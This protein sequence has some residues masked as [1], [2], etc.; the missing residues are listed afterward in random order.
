MSWFTVPEAAI[1][2]LIRVTLDPRNAV[3]VHHPKISDIS[4]SF[5]LF[6]LNGTLCRPRARLMISALPK[7]D[8]VISV[9]VCVCCFSLEAIAWVP[10]SRHCDFDSIVINEAKTTVDPVVKLLRAKMI[11][12]KMFKDTS[13][14]V[15]WHFR[16]TWLPC[17]LPENVS[18]SAS[19]F[20]HSPSAK[21]IIGFRRKEGFKSCFL[22][23]FSGRL[24]WR[25]QWCHLPLT[26]HMGLQGKH[27][28]ASF[29]SCNPI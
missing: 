14:V 17:V 28:S 19:R 10:R 20:G 22:I 9:C 5:Q 11:H 4:A 15:G 21:N 26:L 6:K 3:E 16:N 24:R 18:I 29:F 8:H 7:F 23:I 27:C 1:P 13:A 12:P 2:F 25:R